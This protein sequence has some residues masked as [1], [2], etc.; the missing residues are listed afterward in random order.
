MLDSLIHDSWILCSSTVCDGQT[1]T[2]TV[3]LTVTL[4]LT[5]LKDADEIYFKSDKLHPL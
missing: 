3:T 1:V 4:I 2:V 5:P